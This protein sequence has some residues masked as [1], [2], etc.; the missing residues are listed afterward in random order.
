[1]KNRIFN[2]FY[3]YKSPKNLSK[4][5][6]YLKFDSL[7]IFDSKHEKDVLN[8]LDNL[9]NGL[10]DL[11]GMI[12][13]VGD[14]ICDEIYSLSNITEESN[15]QL[16]NQLSEI[17]STLNVGNLIGVINTYQNYKINRKLSS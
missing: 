11:M 7:N 13:K 16:T 1:M 15:R 10:N 9:E 14:E 12:R 6:E 17:D 2:K 5:T 8:K 3:L 4:E